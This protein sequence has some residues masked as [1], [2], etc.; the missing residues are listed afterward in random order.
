M[1]KYNRSTFALNLTTYVDI[2]DDDWSLRIESF[3]YMGNEYRKILPDFTRDQLCSFIKTTPYIYPDLLKFS[4]F[5]PQK[6]N[7]CP[8]PSK[9]YWLKNYNLDMTNIPDIPFNCKKL[10]GVWH[11]FY[12]NKVEA[13]IGVHAVEN[14]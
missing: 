5:P 11:F 2:I 14:N 6:P 4:N 10:K 7:M 12:K 8:A 13:I 3:G 1:S 9:K